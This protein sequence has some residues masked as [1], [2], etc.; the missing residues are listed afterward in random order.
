MQLEQYAS[1]TLWRRQ[2]SQRFADLPAAWVRGS[3]TFDP[4]SI[5][6]GAQAITTVTVPNATL[7]DVCLTPAFSLDTQGVVLTGQVTAPNTVTVTFR[8]DSGAPVDLGS[9]TLTA[10]VL[11][12]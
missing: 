4:G 2:V 1:E 10:A 12:A 3:K 5:L 9:G 6:S 11:V 7:G 8:N